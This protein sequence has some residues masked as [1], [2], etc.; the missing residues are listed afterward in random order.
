[1]QERD[2]FLTKYFFLKVLFFS[3]LWIVGEASQTAFWLFFGYII[4]QAKLLKTNFGQN[5]F[6]PGQTTN[7]QSLD[8]RQLNQISCDKTVNNGCSIQHN[9]D[10]PMA[11]YHS[12][13]VRLSWNLFAIFFLTLELLFDSGTSFSLVMVSNQPVWFMAAQRRFS[14][15]LVGWLLKKTW[16][17]RW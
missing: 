10:E 16:R 13:C 4:T 9:S 12:Q 11:T 14:Q 17:D 6:V 15:E 1:M 7:V 8:Q 2:W 5:K 3:N